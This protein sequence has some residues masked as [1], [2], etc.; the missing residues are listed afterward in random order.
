MM[1]K[2]KMALDDAEDSQS[3]QRDETNSTADRGFVQKNSQRYSFK[4]TN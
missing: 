4:L 2:I 1:L 3:V